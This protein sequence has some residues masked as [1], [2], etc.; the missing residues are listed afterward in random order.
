MAK[1]RVADY[2]MD[3][4]VKKGITDIFLVSGGGIMFLTDAVGKNKKLNYYSTHHEQTC[5]SAAEAW[6]RVTNE[7]GAC[8]VTTGPGATNAL[9]GVAGAWVDSIPMIVISGQVRTN[10]IADYSKQRQIGPQEGNTIPTVEHNTKYAKLITKPENIGYELEKAHHIA[11]TGRPGPVWLD[12]PLDV[13]GAEIETKKLRKFV[14]KKIDVS[15]AKARLAKQVKKVVKLLQSAERPVLVLGGGVRLAGASESVLPFIEKLNIPVVMPYSGLDLVHEDHPLCMGKFGPVGQRRGNFTLQ[16]SDLMISIGSGMSLAAIG[17]NFKAVAPKAKKVMVNIDAGELTKPTISPDLKIKADAKDF[18]KEVLNQTKKI[19]FTYDPRWKKACSN[20]KK[21]YPNMIDDFYT[22]DF[23]NTYVF[24]DQLSDLLTS[25]D[26]VVTGNSLDAVSMFQALRVKK[27]QRAF[28]NA[29]WGS[30]GWCLPGSIG[31]AA[32][33]KHRTVLVTGDGSI[34]FN[35]QELGTI[36]HYQLPVKIFVINNEGYESIRTT[37]ESHFKSNYVGSSAETGVTN[38]N[39]KDLAKAYTLP[40]FFIKNN[41]QIK[42]ITKQALSVEGP[43][44]VELRVD[45]DQHRVPKVSSFK[46]PDG[47]LESR[48]LEDMAPFLPREE[49]RRNMSLFEEEN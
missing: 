7:P 2:V 20:W 16:N 28:T 32:A 5:A 13:Q 41:N 9:T 25:K 37:Q 26:T 43:V 35:V 21:N 4:L 34:Q 18:I 10:I 15:K 42:K 45:P 39:F 14:P 24:F 6:A 46:R 44:L 11:T 22:K 17:F 19:D 33:S 27:G 30:M 48:P 38:P 23:V 29:N 3:F 8:L 47:T 36:A 31:A 1:K 40:Y 49:V 12:I